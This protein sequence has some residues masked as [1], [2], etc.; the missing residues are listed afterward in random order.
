MISDSKS[1]VIEEELDESKTTYTIE[2][3]PN[4][5]TPDGDGIN[6]EFFLKSDG[7]YNF[8]VVVLNSAN[9]TVFTSQDPNF[10]WDGKD[11]RGNPIPSGNYM[12][13]ITATDSAGNPIKE[14]S[15][16]TVKR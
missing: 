11:L 1:P 10:R 13:Y 8:N 5:F 3:L 12:Y 14:F 2:S 16:L 7:L 6:D 4:I 15:Y 9:Q